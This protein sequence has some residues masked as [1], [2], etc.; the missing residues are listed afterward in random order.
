MFINTIYLCSVCVYSTAL[1]INTRIISPVDLILPFPP[2][3]LTTDI[4]LNLDLQRVPLSI[5]IIILSPPLLSQGVVLYSILYFWRRMEN[6]FRL[7]IYKIFTL[8]INTLFHLLFS[9]HSGT[10]VNLKTIV[11][12]NVYSTYTVFVVEKVQKC[13]II[14]YIIYNNIIQHLFSIYTQS[15]RY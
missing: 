11:A 15:H 9:Y 5:I 13:N 7:I 12:V 4:Y 2:P 3:P 6:S 10:S 14:I 8:K 1:L